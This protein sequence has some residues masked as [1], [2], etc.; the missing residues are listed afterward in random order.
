MLTH[1]WLL[2]IA[3]ALLVGLVLGFLVGD[4]A[5]QSR[6]LWLLRDALRSMNEVVNGHGAGCSAE[7]MAEESPA[8]KSESEGVK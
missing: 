2:S 5:G 7:H 8:V 4:H 1:D 6:V 3:V